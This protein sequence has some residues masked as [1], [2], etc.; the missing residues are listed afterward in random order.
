M[1]F[2]KATIVFQYFDWTVVLSEIPTEGDI[3]KD[4]TVYRQPVNSGLGRMSLNPFGCALH[5]L[6]IA[7]ADC[8]SSCSRWSASSRVLFQLSPVCMRIW[9]SNAR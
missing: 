2:L 9:P 4:L 3:A 1:F 5:A 7:L 6:T 8:S